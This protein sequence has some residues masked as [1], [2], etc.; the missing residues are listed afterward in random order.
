MTRSS[1]VSPYPRNNCAGS[2]A[3]GTLSLNK[4]GPSRHVRSSTPPPLPVLRPV[5]HLLSPPE[6]P[7]TALAVSE[8][9]NGF[10][11]AGLDGEIQLW[12]REGESQGL[13]TSTSSSQQWQRTLAQPVG[14]GEINTLAL[15]GSTL[16]CGC[17]DGSVRVFRLHREGIKFGMYSLL[18]LKHG[19]SLQQN[20][21]EVMS[22]ALSTA[23]ASRNAPLL[24]SGAQDGSVCIWSTRSGQLVQSFSAQG[25]WVMALLLERV[26]EA[27]EGVL[28]TAGYDKLVKTWVRSGE[29]PMS[30]AG[31]GDTPAGWTAQMTFEGHTDGVLSLALS[32]QRK[33][34]LSGGND[35]T[36]RGWS[37]ERGGCVFVLAAHQSAVTSL[38][39][40]FLSGC[41]VSGC[42]EGAVRLWNVD[43][44][45][46]TAARLDGTQA[47]AGSHN[48]LDLLLQ[49]VDKTPYEVLCI[50]PTADG[51]GLLC[52]LVDGSIVILN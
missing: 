19:A 50:C 28:V 7:V 42:E 44:L 38:S 29:G 8:C 1:P 31:G 47:V 9:G 32:R 33:L 51:T 18:Q 12:S 5:G 23:F 52:G 10:V 43:A 49:G 36:V 11:S 4:M 17:M 21:N 40:H 30:G 34:I 24:V 39:W 6:K 27:R 3:T 14:G 41:L 48:V 15:L 13:G 25:S 2:T 22:V 46:A 35:H 26:D 20:T 37:L 16:A 45:E